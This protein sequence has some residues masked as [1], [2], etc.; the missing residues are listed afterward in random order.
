MDIKINQIKNLLIILILFIII[1]SVG[2]ITDSDIK[3]DTENK[4]TIIYGSMDL[5]S[6]YPYSIKLNNR[7]V[8]LCNIYNGLVEFNEFFQINPSLA[9]NWIN[10]DDYT[11]RFFLR[12]NVKFHNG[13]AFNSDDVKYSLNSTLYPTYQSFIKDIK[14]I[15]D[16][17]IDIITN[18]PYPGLLQRLAHT[19]IVFPSKQPNENIELPIG[20]GPYKFVEYIE[21]NYTKIELFENYW[22][23]KPKIDEVI[24]KFIEDQEKRIDELISGKINIADYN[25]DENIDILINESKI[26][27]EKCPPLSNY[28]IGFDVR[29]NN[30]YGFP[31]GNN[32]TADVRVRRA[33]YHAIDIVP[34]ING[35]F[36]GYAKPASQLLTQYI[37]GYNPEIKRLPY[38]QTLAKELLNESGYINGFEMEMDCIT[39]GYEYNKIN[40]E[41]IKE[42]LSKVGI[43]IKIN[44][45]SA[46]E[47]NNKV[48]YE[49]NTSLWLVGWSPASFDGGFVYDLFI[50]TIGENIIGFYNS[51]H[52][53][54]LKVDEL[55]I[56]AS[57]EMNP[58]FRSKLLQEGF[59][60]ALEEDVFS[61]PLFSQ[62]LLI[63]TSNDIILS[64]RA[65]SRFL[66]SDI[67]IL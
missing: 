2:C 37:F 48:I 29:E 1:I 9:T 62:E 45:L 63:L 26:N 11:W 3:D 34:L 20:T 19:F 28:I 16:Y 46:E 67:D 61:I 6:I 33:F 31:D 13:Q 40:C 52:Y 12:E 32:P 5:D 47:F 18:E 53:S 39:I 64:P 24:F 15:D 21:N 49:K 14:I 27:I 10:L 66:A 50:R 58:T 7:Y 42:Q 55:G 23:E 36:R 8:L 60:I 38:N 44:Y 59:K 25:I 54:N 65:D 57:T 30:S 17:T 35:P 41:Q 22:G 56:Q 43:E 51:G 4:K